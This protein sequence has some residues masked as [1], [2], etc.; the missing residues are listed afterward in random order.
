[1]EHLKTA[2]ARNCLF[3]ALRADTSETQRNQGIYGNVLII[4]SLIL[5]ISYKQL[6]RHVY[7]CGDKGNMTF[8]FVSNILVSEREDHYSTIYFSSGQLAYCFVPAVLISL[9]LRLLILCHLQDVWC[10]WAGTFVSTLVISLFS[11]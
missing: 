1:M 10:A 9:W 11:L 5:I 4:K 3:I 2:T 7:I 8:E 6:L